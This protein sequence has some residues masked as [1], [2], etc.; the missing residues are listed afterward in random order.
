MSLG[1]IL[2]VPCIIMALLTSIFPCLILNGPRKAASDIAEFVIH[3]GPNTV[4]GA[5]WLA[6]FIRMATLSSLAPIL[7]GG[8]PQVT[9]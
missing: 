3:M 7:L 4:I 9:D 1:T 6:C 8:H 2:F 5:I